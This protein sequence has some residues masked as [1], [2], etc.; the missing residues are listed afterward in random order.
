M[1][2]Q[3]K[4]KKWIFAIL[5]TTTTTSVMRK[6]HE[7][8]ETNKQTKKKKENNMLPS[9]WT[10]YMEIILPLDEKSNKDEKERKKK[11]HV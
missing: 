2:K 3:C 1:H 10:K 7:F 6:L 5:I 8:I 4:K 9:I 11:I